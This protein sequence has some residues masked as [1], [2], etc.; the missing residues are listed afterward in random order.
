MNILF[1]VAA[2]LSTVIL[3]LDYHVNKELMKDMDEIRILSEKLKMIN[4]CAD[5][6]EKYKAEK[7]ERLKARI[8]K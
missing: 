1:L 2:V 3:A 8:N 5:E 6:V 4:Q 7:T